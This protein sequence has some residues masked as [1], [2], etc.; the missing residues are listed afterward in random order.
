MQWMKHYGGQGACTNRPC[1]GQGA[2][3]NRP[4]GEV[5]NIRMRFS[6]TLLQGLHRGKLGFC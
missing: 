2:C 5:D 3:I 4:C 1:G 6:S